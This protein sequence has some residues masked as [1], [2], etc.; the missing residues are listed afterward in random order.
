MILVGTYICLVDLSWRW[1]KH[2]GYLRW[3]SSSE[4]G[5]TLFWIPAWLLGVSVILINLVDTLMN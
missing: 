2:D 3:W 4:T 5:G 1:R